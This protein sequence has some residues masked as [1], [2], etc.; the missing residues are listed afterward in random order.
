[1]PTLNEIKEMCPLFEV[2]TREDGR[3]TCRSYGEGGLCVSREDGACVVFPPARPKGEEENAQPSPCSA[4]PGASRAVPV[5]KVDP[6][7]ALPTVPSTV[8]VQVDLPMDLAGNAEREVEGAHGF[9]RAVT[10]PE[11]PQRTMQAVAA[12]VQSMTW[13]WT[14]VQN[15]RKCPFKWFLHYIEELVPEF[16]PQ[17]ATEGKAYHTALESVYRSRGTTLQ[18]EETPD[19]VLNAQIEG[20]L[21]GLMRVGAIYLPGDWEIEKRVDFEV[22]TSTGTVPWTT[23]LDLVSA[24]GTVIVD[25]KTMG[26]DPAAA[27]LLDVLYQMAL[28]R[29]AEPRVERF[30]INAIRKPALKLGKSETPE[31]FRD[32]I[33]A[34]VVK[35]PQFYFSRLTYYVTE[36]NFSRYFAEL[37]NEIELIKLAAGMGNYPRFRHGCKFGAKCEFQAECVRRM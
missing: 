34:D 22:A 19:P 4:T 25:H 32:R 37:V 9:G 31:E 27:L 26:S 8:T 36:V 33:T 35:R 7:T 24:D 2:A 10:T 16:E 3:S 5:D 30:V 12:V 21:T 17:W 11:R 15:W 28:Y 29:M 14:R 23:R 18:I 13:S 20:V 1:M 6:Q